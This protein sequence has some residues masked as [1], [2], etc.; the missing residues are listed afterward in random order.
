MNET[1]IEEGL[2]IVCNLFLLV[3]KRKKGGRKKDLLII[4]RS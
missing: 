2:I 4:T 1:E 3:K